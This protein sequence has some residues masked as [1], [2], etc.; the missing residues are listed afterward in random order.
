MDDNEAV[1]TMPQ[2]L[3]NAEVPFRAWSSMPS[4]PVS[5]TDPSFDAL[6][7]SF[8]HELPS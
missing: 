1:H 3:A 7:Q 5:K 4:M 8:C 2:T 6:A